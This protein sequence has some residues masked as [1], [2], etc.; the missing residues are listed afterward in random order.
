MLL[1]WN[2]DTFWLLGSVLLTLLFC[3]IL[4]HAIPDGNEYADDGME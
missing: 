3:T 4:R 2:P 1:H